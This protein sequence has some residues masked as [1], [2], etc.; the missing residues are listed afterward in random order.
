MNAK[1]MVDSAYFIRGYATHGYPSVPIYP[2][3]HGCFRLPIPDARSVFNWID[4]RH[5]GR[6]VPLSR[7]APRSRPCRGAAR[8]CRDA[9]PPR[10]VMKRAR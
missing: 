1:G 4:D 8:P 10:A 2:A 6:R 7:G 9:G 5:A 3:S